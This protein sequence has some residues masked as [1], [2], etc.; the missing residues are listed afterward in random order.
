MAPPPTTQ[1]NSYRPATSEGEAPM[2]PRIRAVPPAGSAEAPTACDVGPGM[3]H[4]YPRR[5]YRKPN[6]SP[7]GATAARR[8]EESGCRAARAR[9]AWRLRASL[10]ALRGEAVVLVAV[11]VCVR[12]STVG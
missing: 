6:V 11:T 4:E 7:A 1:I 10:S 3:P 9:S 12:T 2:A 8:P 5:K